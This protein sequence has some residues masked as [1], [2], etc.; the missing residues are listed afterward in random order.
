MMN[1]DFAKTFLSIW[2]LTLLTYGQ[3]VAQKT[4]IKSDSSKTLIVIQDS[5]K[6][7]KID[8]LTENI[9]IQLKT[10]QEK[11]GVIKKTVET[12]DKNTNDGIL[13]EGSKNFLFTL[14]Y[15]LLG[16]KSGSSTSW[17][18][19]F[20]S[21]ISFLFLLFRIFFFF[22]KKDKEYPKFTK[23]IN[24]YLVGL[25]IF[26]LLLPWTASFFPNKEMDKEQIL[27]VTENAKKLNL[28]IEKIQSSDFAKLVSDI[29][30]L[31]RL[32]VDTI[33]LAKESSI[34]AVE[35]KFYLL[36]NQLTLANK[37]IDGLDNKISDIKREE[38][39]AR[40][41]QQVFQTWLIVLT[42]LMM[43]ICFIFFISKKP[44]NNKT[45]NKHFRKLGRTDTLG[46][47]STCR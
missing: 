26:A 8:S 6:L 38:N 22:S 36:Q 44:W 41:G 29:Q 21:F 25:A 31:Q 23:A 17:F 3:G 15:E 40:R 34:K 11:T 4:V 32:R 9:S 7:N 45:S 42:F 24:I 30:E 46:K 12:I 37:K 13:V 28:E 47:S 19:K 10:L 33:Q 35:T 1:I 16:Y 18:S 43:A 39:N 2:M 20:V 14:I 27:Q 5:I